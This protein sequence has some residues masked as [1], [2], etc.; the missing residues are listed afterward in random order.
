ML[1]VVLLA[2]ALIALL[3]APQDLATAAAGDNSLVI[4]DVRVFD[5]EAFIERTS[6]LIR[7]GVIADMTPALAIP[8]E[9]MVIDGSGK[10]VLP[11]LIDAHTHSYGDALK[12]SLR[13]GV[14]ANVDMFTAAA[15]L[16][17]QKNRRDSV[18]KVVSADLFSAGV[19]A[20]APGG[21]GTQ[22]GVPVET[23]S[24][25][26]DAPAWVARRKAEG[27]DFIKLVYIPAQ[28]RIPSLDRATAAAVIRAAH[29]E[30]LLAVAHISTQQAASDLVDEGVDGLVHMFADEAATPEFVSR[31]A[32][33]R[34]FIV[35]TLS[36]LA[37]VDGRSTLR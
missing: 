34:L 29:A 10:T 33:K 7:D 35:P 16:T 22:F 28:D 4:T 9:I 18:A 37:S 21:H 14:T 25:A 17:G 8:D 30:D 27:S 15:L 26:E 3:P 1:V 6:L 31:A 23:L 13:F 24:S 32:A 36:I 11:G 12:T 20:T 5:G 2:G 19:L